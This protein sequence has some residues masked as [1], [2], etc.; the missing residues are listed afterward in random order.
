VRSLPSARAGIFETEED[1]IANITAK[2]NRIAAAMPPITVN[3]LI[4]SC[5]GMIPDLNLVLNLD[6]SELQKD[7]AESLQYL[8]KLE[9]QQIAIISINICMVHNQG[10]EDGMAWFGMMTP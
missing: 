10:T 5:G 2:K 3:I 1:D 9:T 7:K 8:F 6:R 4:I